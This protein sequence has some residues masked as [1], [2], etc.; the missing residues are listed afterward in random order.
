MHR[1]NLVFA[2]VALTLGV[3]LLFGRAAWLCRKRKVSLMQALTDILTRASG[4]RTSPPDEYD[5]DL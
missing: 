4:G 3:F 2:V 1:A 5:V